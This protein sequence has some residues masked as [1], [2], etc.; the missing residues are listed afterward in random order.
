MLVIRF[1]IYFL[2]YGENKDIFER[3]AHVI[4]FYAEAPFFVQ[5]EFEIAAVNEMCDEGVMIYRTRSKTKAKHAKERE[6]LVW[7]IGTGFSVAPA[8]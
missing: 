1:I 4:Q 3:N 6:K 2:T 7:S 8:S 5:F